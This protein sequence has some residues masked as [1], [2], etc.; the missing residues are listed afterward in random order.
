MSPIDAG[1]AFLKKRTPRLPGPSEKWPSGGHVSQK[2]KNIAE[3]RITGQRGLT[4]CKQ[5]F[6][7]KTK[8][9]HKS[10]IAE[11]RLSMEVVV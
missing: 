9:G 2:I 6:T 10:R 8:Q 7:K 1:R 11:K 4:D 5:R 3:G